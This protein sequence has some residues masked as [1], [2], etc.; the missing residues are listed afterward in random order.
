MKKLAL[1]ALSATTLLA[2]PALA[3][4]RGW[5]VGIEGGLTWARDDGIDFDFDEFDDGEIIVAAATPA[6]VLE[7]VL[8]VDY[9][10]GYDVD[11]LVGYDWGWLRTELEL[12]HKR[13]PVISRTRRCCERR[14]RL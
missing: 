11:A 12:G 8:G 9:K 3:A 7:N 1:A 13:S 10:G 4:D 6:A 2:T 14:V 5:Y